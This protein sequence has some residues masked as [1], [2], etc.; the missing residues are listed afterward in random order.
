[1]S[2]RSKWGTCKPTCCPGPRP[3]SVILNTEQ[4]SQQTGSFS[5]LGRRLEW[6]SLLQLVLPVTCVVPGWP[7][8]SEELPRSQRQLP[9]IR[10]YIFP[11]RV[12]R[13]PFHLERRSSTPLQ[14]YPFLGP[15]ELRDGRPHLYSHGCGT[16]DCLGPHQSPVWG[17]QPAFY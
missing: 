10:N 14:P 12:S 11:S 7:L 1:M 2:S 13:A 5:W 8:D 6:S 3:Q 15:R 17:P 16:S 9:L 4:V